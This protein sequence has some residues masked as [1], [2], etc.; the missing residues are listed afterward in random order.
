MN[1]PPQFRTVLRGYDP[2]QVAAV[3]ADLTSSLTVARRT[4]ADRTMELTQAQQLV[5]TL[6][7]ERD[8]AVERLTADAG[9]GQGPSVEVGGRVSAILSLADEEAGQL[10]TEAEQYAD[11]LR[12]SA[13][14]EANRIRAGAAETADRLVREADQAAE[15]QREAVA[16]RQAELAD[17]ERGAA[18]IIESA[19]REAEL[20]TRRARADTAEAD[21]A[22]DRVATDLHGVLEVLARLQLEMGDDDD[23]PVPTWN[24]REPRPTTRAVAT[25]DT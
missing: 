6:S 11:E 5:A 7:E 17:A 13:E 3:V 16:T 10:R 25:A 14:A 2:E 21:R 4:A 18:Q 19:R 24:Q 12:R 8:E 22:R 15:T 1:E 23:T 9:S 20:E